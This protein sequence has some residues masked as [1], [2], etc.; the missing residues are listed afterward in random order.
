MNPDEIKPDPSDTMMSNLDAAIREASANVAKSK[1]DLEKQRD[2]LEAYR[3]KVDRRVR[4]RLPETA[5]H[6]C[7]KCKQVYNLVPFSS[8][9]KRAYT[10]PI[11]A[12]ALNVDA[13]SLAASKEAGIVL[14]VMPTVL[15]VAAEKFASAWVK[16][17]EEKGR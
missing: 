2:A 6:E 4:P 11:C 3:Q 14:V 8:E 13:N 12:K 9:S 5:P 7:P 15:E 16:M 1:K 17:I 10:C